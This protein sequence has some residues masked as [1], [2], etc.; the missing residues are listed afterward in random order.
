MKP[1]V[2]LNSES[3]ETKAKRAQLEKD[4]KAFKK[5]G[6]KIQQIPFG[7]SANVVFEFVIHTGDKE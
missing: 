1:L 2:S 7:K 5:K 4:V 6:G 3:P